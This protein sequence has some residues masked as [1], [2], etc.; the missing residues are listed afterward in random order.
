MVKHSRHLIVVLLLLIGHA[1]TGNGWL[2][3]AGAAD[4]GDVKVRALVDRNQVQPGESLGF[5]VVVS[6]GDGVVDLAPLA[7]FEIRSQGTATQISMINMHTTREVTH[8]YQLIPRKTGTLTIPALTVDVDGTRMR[9]RPIQITVAEQAADG[10]QR[11]IFVEVDLSQRTPYV[12]QQ[13][14]Y[15]FTLYQAVQITDGRLEQPDFKGFEVHEFDERPTRRKVIDGREYVVT[16]VSYLLIPLTAGHA[17]IAPA[18]LSFGL[19]KRQSR[20]RSN[21]LDDFFNDSF[22]GFGRT[23]VEPRLLTSA[24]LEVDV[25]PLPTYSGDTP[26]SGLVGQFQL[27]RQVAQASLKVGESTTLTIKISGRGN[28][29]DAQEP[30]LSVPPAFKTYTDAP[31]VDIKMDGS[32][33]NGEKVFRTALVPVTAGS[34]TLPESRL[35]YF[36]PV[37]GAYQ[38]A[39]TGALDLVVAPGEGKPDAAVAVMATPAGGDAAGVGRKKKV[40]FTGKDIL[41]LKEGLEALE[42]PRRLGPALF[43]TLLILPALAFAAL[44]GALRLL[45][46]PADTRSRMRR[47]ARHFLKS[48][49]ASTDRE[50]FLK[51]LRRTLVAAVMGAT[52]GAGE[53]LTADEARQ[54]LENSGVAGA[55]ATEAA[56]LLEEIDSY[57]YSGASLTDEGRKRL[58]HRTRDLVG[59][60]LK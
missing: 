49:T 19:V 47:K 56:Q 11:D 10:S 40:G 15:T 32:G 46:P 43:W 44:G 36:D 29:R 9:T 1:F 7:D 45:K 52:G 22:F 8:T 21:R 3:E 51:A 60:V 17:T 58:Q 37:Q 20:N 59:K 25:R 12:G 26:F 34:F 48:A 4:G 24:S 50:A 38:D 18:R 23:Q 33:F 55:T 31:T 54:R 5:K 13:I 6:G 42:A 2:P 27:S 14:R 28:I 41:P 39:R 30:P 35:V 16:E 57:H 53:A